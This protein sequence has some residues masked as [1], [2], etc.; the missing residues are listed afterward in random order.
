VCPILG[1]NCNAELLIMGAS[2]KA[3]IIP[4]DESILSVVTELHSAHFLYFYF[5]IDLSAFCMK[6]NCNAVGYE[7]G[8]L[9]LKLL[10]ACTQIYRECHKNNTLVKF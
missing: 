2:F 6:K 8:Y 7:K 9:L 3:K 10:Q 1:A 4:N 5:Q